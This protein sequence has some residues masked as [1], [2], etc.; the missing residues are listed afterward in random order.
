MAQQRH[1]YHDRDGVRRSLI[2]EDDEPDKFVVHT[3]QDLEP[4]IELIAIEREVMRNN[5]PNKLLGHVPVCVAERAVHEQ[6]GE[7]DWRKWWNGQGPDDLPNGRAFRV[8]NP[9]WNV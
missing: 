8:W 1:Y 7:D 6:W 3:E 2:W 4:L 9:S 5:G